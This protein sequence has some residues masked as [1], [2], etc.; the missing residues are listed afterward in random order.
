MKKLAAAAV[1][2]WPCKSSRIRKILGGCLGN[3][4]HF[5]KIFKNWWRYLPI[6]I[7]QDH[8]FSIAVTGEIK[9]T[10]GYAAFFAAQLPCWNTFFSDKFKH[11]VQ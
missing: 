2:S 7:K 8:M 3:Q 6:R 4:R 5:L 1:V 10:Q 11:K 9:F